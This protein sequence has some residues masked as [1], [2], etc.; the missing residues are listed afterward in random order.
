MWAEP[1]VERTAAVVPAAGLTADRIAEGEEPAVS[2]E[3]A[4]LTTPD[5]YITCV[6][7]GNLN[8][9]HNSSN[10]CTEINSDNLTDNCNDGEGEFSH[11]KPVID[12]LPVELSDND[13]QSIIDLIYRNADVFSK[14]E[15]DLGCTDL[16]KYRIDTGEHRPISEGLRSHPRVHLDVIDQAVDKLLEA[17]V[18]EESSGEWAFNVVVVSKADGSTPRTTIDYRRLNEITYKDRFPLP[19]VADCLDAMSGSMYFSTVDLSSS[20]YQIEIDE[21]D[22]D[23]TA[24]LTRKGQF[25]FR[26]MPMGG[27]N[28]PSVFSRLM[29]LALRGLPPLVCVCYIDDCVI[30]GR[31]L[32]E[33][34][35]NVEMVLARFRAAK[36]KL[37]PSKCKLFQLR[38]HFLGHIVSS[39]GIEVDPDKVAC[40]LAWEFPENVSQLRSFIGLCSYYRAF[41]SGFSTIAEPL[42]EML[43]KGVPVKCTDRRFEAFNQLKQMLTSAPV[44]ALPTDEDEYVLDCDASLVGAGAILQQYQNGVLRVIEYASRT[45]NSAERS[46]CVTRREMAALIFGLRHFRQYLLGRHFV[47][48]VDHMALTF[49]RKSREPTGQ[50]A[51]H[52]DFIAEFDF[53]IQYR[54]GIRHRNCDSLSRLRPCEVDGG[55]PCRQCNRRVTGRHG[56]TRDDALADERNICR[57]TTRAQHKRQTDDMGGDVVGWRVEQAEHCGADAATML[58]SRRPDKAT[59]PSVVS[60][61]EGGQGERRTTVPSRCHRRSRRRKGDR[62]LGRTAPEAIAIGG[63]NWN[64]TFLR[65]QQLQDIDIQPVLTWIEGDCGRPQWDE[66]KS[67]SPFLRSLWQQY[68]SLVTRE[69]ALYRIFHASDGQVLY[70]QLVLPASLK[71]AFLQ[72]THADAAGHLKLIKCIEHVKRRAWWFTWRRDLKLFIDCCTV[73][74]A[75]HRGSAPKQG[76]LHPMVLGGVAERWSIDLTGPH[77][78]S[79]GYKYLFTALCPFSKYGIAVPIRN[80]EAATVAR[81]LVDH[82]FLK[83]GLCF[84][85]L[86]DQGKEFE[87]ELMEAL[88]KILGVV[89]LR[90]SGYRPQCNGAVEAWHKVL[91]TLLAKAMSE[92]Q[93]DWSSYVGYVTFCYNATPHSSTGFAPHFLM[94]G[95]QPRWNVDFLLN[96]VNESATTVPEYTA[97]VL[98]RLDRAHALTREHLRQTAESMS[99]WYNRKVRARSFMRGDTV[100][101][102]NPR[103]FIGRSPKWQSFY[104]DV[105]IIEQ[106]L[107]DVTYIVKSKAWKH[108]KVVHVDKL[109]LVSD[110]TV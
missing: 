97:V 79:N 45:F 44:L 47:V 17:G 107:N 101:V 88:L 59:L 108:N 2:R 23:K 14:H 99:T 84:E 73:C 63:E 37:K 4:G 21:R 57:V 24:F 26:R 70:Y 89:K 40:I 6:G 87:A 83:W 51:R 65:E 78:P 66:V 71:V 38:V 53:D 110:V 104:R 9:W 35:H 64:P 58:A 18:V 82:V 8:S 62:M 56:A 109:K 106:R 36:L 86:S 27:A 29:S 94:T 49:Y 74:S 55:E 13:R 67:A 1:A 31:D 41:C 12:A 15:F 10:C 61:W 22:R 103:R 54:E 11:V 95:Q 19:R 52:L 93:R 69:G 3:P 39:N 5:D 91:N 92:S 34:M 90:T 7:R 75:Y 85:I 98:S 77:P 80:K 43:R 33:A 76:A 16:L 105:G 68:E 72:L 102:Y 20:F 32:E 96:C 46:Y 25:R 60:D 30:L 42:T 81:A 100:R 48:R 50:Q 28:C